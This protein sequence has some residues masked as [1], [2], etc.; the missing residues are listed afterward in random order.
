MTSFF[1]YSSDIEQPSGIPENI[2]RL[3]SLPFPLKWKFY[4][5]PE[6]RAYG[7]KAVLGLSSGREG[8]S[9]V[10]ALILRAARGLRLNGQVREPPEHGH[11]H[12]TLIEVHTEGPMQ[13]SRCCCFDKTG[14]KPIPLHA[15]V[16]RSPAFLSAES[17][18]EPRK[19]A[20]SMLP[21]CAR[22]RERGPQSSPQ[23]ICSRVPQ[24]HNE[25]TSTVH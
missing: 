9:V 3:Q 20:N 22:P 19:R 18:D 15:H 21:A 8:C 6:A 2:L 10:H 25:R 11:L 5:W 7:D 14:N 16:H 24:L 4:E 23:A 17:R 1:F 12:K 13:T